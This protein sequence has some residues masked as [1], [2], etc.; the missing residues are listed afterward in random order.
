M[1]PSLSFG[2]DDHIL[3]PSSLLSTQ[4]SASPP[5][6][7]GHLLRYGGQTVS[8]GQEAPPSSFKFEPSQN[9]W[10][11][12]MSI[13]LKDPIS[14]NQPSPRFFHTAVFSSLGYDKMIV[15]GGTDNT[16]GAL[17]DTWELDLRLLQWRDLTPTFLRGS[18]TFP[19]ARYQHS[20]AVHPAT[21]DMF[22]VGGIN[23]TSNIIDTDIVWKLIFNTV[24]C[25]YQWT[26]ISL[27]IQGRAQVSLI[28]S[29]YPT[30]FN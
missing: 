2:S 16:G 24:T 10:E 27:S 1:L 11:N 8:L 7:P 5:G 25:M 18:N 23:S 19:T 26:R 4:A 30:S 28:L 6:R 12:I 20:A 9:E 13:T 21:G 15:Y 17:E 3:L 14:N 29:I 22:V